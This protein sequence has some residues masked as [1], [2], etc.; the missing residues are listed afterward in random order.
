MAFTRPFPSFN[1][2]QGSSILSKLGTSPNVVSSSA[3]LRRS[4]KEKVGSPK[5][6]PA[7]A[8]R[9]LQKFDLP[10]LRERLSPER[11]KA[12]ETLFPV[13]AQLPGLAENIVQS[14]GRTLER[15]STKPGRQEL[16]ESLRR[17]LTQR[18]SLQTI[19]EPAVESALDISDFIP[20]LGFVSLGTKGI[21]KKAARELAEKAAKETGKKA[22]KKAIKAQG[23]LEAIGLQKPK[24]PQ[25]PKAKG[26][27]GEGKVKTLPSDRFTGRT[28]IPIGKTDK[29]FNGNELESPR[30]M[31][32]TGDTVAKKIEQI[33]AGERPQV[34]IGKNGDQ[35]VVID[36][37][38]T[39]E[40]YKQLGI[41]DIP[42]I[43][44]TGDNIT[45]PNVA[46]P[47]LLSDI[48][49]EAKK[50]KSAEEFVSKQKGI[51]A[52]HSTDMPVDTKFSGNTQFTTDKSLFRSR[53]KNQVEAYIDLKNP[54]KSTT[55]E[56]PSFDELAK[57]GYDG[58]IN[59]TGKIVIPFNENAIKTKSQLTNIYNQ[60]KGTTK[61]TKKPTK[62]IDLDQDPQKKFDERGKEKQPL[63][64]KGKGAIF[65]RVY[66]QLRLE[67]NVE[68]N[69]NSIALRDQAKKAT[70]F[71]EKNPEDAIA[72]SL[73]QQ[74]PPAGV[75]FNAINIATSKQALANGELQLY[76]DLVSARS[77]IVS[78]SAQSLGLERL[79]NSLSTDTFVQEV[80]R[81]R[82]QK[83]ST[84]GGFVS[85][86]K[87]SFKKG[88]KISL[89]L[90]I[91]SDS[92]T[93]LKKSIDTKV[94]KK[95]ASAQEIIDKLTCK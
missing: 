2:K 18:P 44:K 58:Y 26:V 64:K 42:V 16:G 77:I 43:D 51:K 47:P 83:L 75:T 8:G 94:K 68:D 70:N 65:D 39:L 10:N 15:V 82:I 32:Y 9:F 50:Y 52:F 19:Q 27:V 30:S 66:D 89:G 13:Q 34:T 95:I 81:S 4:A 87:D 35:V 3:T 62:K 84:K 40:A 29:I 46:Q 22:T 38:H 60:A 45:K 28:G 31:G 57:Q 74:A 78:R 33:K 17:V 41:K 69:F 55:L 37:N 86:F 63:I 54:Y 11:R 36:G 7:K 91:I 71:M 1:E 59:R 23:P 73:R 25:P 72:V 6:L 49:Q 12:L 14:Y 85:K 79:V 76:T 93:N 21:S 56:H 53:G 67:T 61:P 88:G 90:D 24:P 80:F 92:A 48:A 20:G 5:E